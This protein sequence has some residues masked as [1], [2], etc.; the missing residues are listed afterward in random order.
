MKKKALDL[1]SGTE[2]ATEAFQ[3]SDNWEVVTVDIEEEH[4]PNIAADVT[5]LEPSDLPD[6]IDFVWA[7]PPCTV[8]SK[9]GWNWHWTNELMPKKKKVAEHV[10]IV[11]HT[12]WLIQEIEPD[13]WFMENPQGLLKSALTIEPSGT[14]TYCQ[15]GADYMKPTQLFGHHPESF[16][17]KRC[18]NG[19]SCHVS[20][21]R[22]KKEWRD[23]TRKEAKN[24]G[25]DK[26]AYRA[27]IPYELSKSILEAVENPGK[28]K[29][30]SK[31]DVL[32]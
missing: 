10:K 30:Q 17:Y 26:Q 4:E 28:K 18:S 16:V 13:Y 12:L 14:V 25:E 7:S 2:S 8:F 27:R 5:E 1:F 11:Y 29:S 19:D 22:H 21:P 32:M 3:R 31:L 9:A 15:Y 24:Q 20:N 23:G 6:N